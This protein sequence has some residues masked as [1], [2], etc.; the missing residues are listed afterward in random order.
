[1]K[2]IVIDTEE[3]V[4]NEVLAQAIASILHDVA[5]INEPGVYPY[6]FSEKE[7]MRRGEFSFHPMEEME[8]EKPQP[9]TEAMFL[10]ETHEEASMQRLG[11]KIQ[12]IHRHWPSIF[13][14]SILHGSDII[15]WLCRL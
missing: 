8:E 14:L 9:K 6:T 12:F 10:A 13:L 15:E 2:R 7:G 1:M 4:D 5:T 11:M 3:G